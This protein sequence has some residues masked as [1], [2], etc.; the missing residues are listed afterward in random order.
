MSELTTLLVFLLDSQR[1]ALPLEAV[2]R[3]VRAA[4][5]TPLPQA[6]QIVLGVLDLRGTIL[7]VLNVRRR[8]RLPERAILPS[9][10]F[11]IARA[12]ERPVALVID[13]AAEVLELS[14][15]QIVAGKALVPG[16][17]HVQGVARMSDGLILIHD[18]ET[19][20]SLDEAAALDRAMSANEEVL[21]GA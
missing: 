21:H 18:L 2:E 20:L 8:F 5:I 14:P 9:D 11:L 4:A 15:A 10:Q 19:F 1:Y 16:L 17:E 7:P 12:G 6:P 3:T 13:A